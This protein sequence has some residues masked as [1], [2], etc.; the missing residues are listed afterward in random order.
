[1][2]LTA[3]IQH[4]ADFCFPPA[5]VVRRAPAETAPLCV[6]CF[7]KLRKLE[8][9]AACERCAM[10]VAE[11]GAPCPHCVGSGVRP[12]GRVL[13]L[14]AYSSPVREMIHSLKFHRAWGLGEFLAERIFARE[15]VASML[16]DCDVIVPVP[17][18]AARHVSRGYN[19]AEIIARRLGKLSR[20]RLSHPVV[21]V[22]HT[23]AQTDVQSKTQRIANLRGAFGLIDQ[24]VIKGQRVVVVD[25]VRTTAATLRAFGRVVRSAKPASLDA[26]VIAAAD[27]KHSDF[28]KL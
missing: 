23:H 10:P 3:A 22:A 1:M 14:G 21:R 24:S 15:E 4:F 18:H 5:C 12:Y 2:K 20:K 9:A 7:G 8:L 16:H 25:D 26:I 11:H 27:P 19:Q 28:E 13:R 17:L 6:E